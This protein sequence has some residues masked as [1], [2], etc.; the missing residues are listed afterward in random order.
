MQVPDAVYY[1]SREKEIR[2]VHEAW[3]QRNLE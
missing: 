3:E 1:W 2:G